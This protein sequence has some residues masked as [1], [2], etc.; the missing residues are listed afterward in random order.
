MTPDYLAGLWNCQ[1]SFALFQ[2]LKCT[3]RDWILP[4]WEIV[5]WFKMA[6]SLALQF[7]RGMAHLALKRIRIPPMK[8]VSLKKPFWRRQQNQWSETTMWQ[9]RS[10]PKNSGVS[11]RLS[12]KNYVLF[13]PL[14]PERPPTSN[15]KTFKNH[16]GCV[17][18]SGC[19]FFGRSTWCICPCRFQKPT[20]RSSSVRIL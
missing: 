13:G 18:C 17:A 3:T 12:C 9:S 8:L 5:S 20:K 19:S 11:L 10:S 1:G 16:P 7:L 6:D 15:S 14:W 2:F 4:S